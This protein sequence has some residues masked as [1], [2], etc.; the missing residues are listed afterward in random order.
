MPDSSLWE[1]KKKRKIKKEE[2]KQASKS[3]PSHHFAEF[4]ALLG[5]LNGYN[6]YTKGSHVVC[7]TADSVPWG[8]K[9][10]KTKKACH[11]RAKVPVLRALV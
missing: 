1:K 7:S 10:P 3:N 11:I 2:K 6:L 5:L 4:S 8:G 9:N